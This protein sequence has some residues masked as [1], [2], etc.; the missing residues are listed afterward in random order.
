M[1]G[2]VAFLR[3][4][5]LGRRTVKSAELKAAV[6]ALGFARVRTLLASGNVLFE[7]KTGPGLAAQLET[8]LHGTFGFEIGVVLRRQE[9]LQALVAADPFA[10]RR[11]DDDTKLHVTLLARP[12]A[13]NLPMPCAEPGDFEVVHRTE[14]EIFILAHR[15]P[16]GRFGPGMER[17]GKH[18]GK[19]TLWTSRNWNTVCK[20]AAG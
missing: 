16:G 3:G 5:N 1:T 19:T 15:Q 8:A 2:W 13:G 14:G 9:A 11:E 10:G 4:V 7:A 12:E 17:I 20:A 6:E 18:F